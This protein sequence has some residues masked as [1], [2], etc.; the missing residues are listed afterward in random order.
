MRSN[1]A[2]KIK[3]HRNP[4]LLNEFDLAD[5]T[6]R[7]VVASV[8]RD[9]LLKRGCPFVKINSSVRYRLSDV[10]AYLRP[11]P[12]YGPAEGTA[13]QCSSPQQITNRQLWAADG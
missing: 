6:K 9:R 4:T 5:V 7:S 1:R 10:D 12:T 8:R 13:A 3:S 11:L 2:Y